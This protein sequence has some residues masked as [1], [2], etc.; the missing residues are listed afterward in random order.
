MYSPGRRPTDGWQ[1]YNQP[2]LN[3]TQLHCSALHRTA[4][5][6]TTLDYNALPGIALHCTELHWRI[7]RIGKLNFDKFNFGNQFGQFNEIWA[8]SGPPYRDS[9]VSGPF[10]GCQSGAASVGATVCDFL[11]AIPGRRRPSRPL[12]IWRRY[13]THLKNYTTVFLGH[14]FNSLVPAH[15]AA[16]R[17]IIE[18]KKFY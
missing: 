14:N 1:L 5:H 18:E 6:C 17:E 7:S 13:N 16:L 4:L 3:C 11:V 15:S 2:A 8:F 9:H 10:L 12:S